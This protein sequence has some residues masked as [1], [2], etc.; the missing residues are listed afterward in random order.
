M[1]SWAFRRR[2]LYLSVIFLII[3]IPLGTYTYVK[4]QKP[5]SCMDN[6][7]NQNEHGVDCGGICQVACMYEVQAYPTI[8]WARAYYVS[9]G[10][11]NLVA[12]LQNPNTSYISKPVPYIFNVYDQNNALIQSKEGVVAF[13]TTKL[14]PIFTP[15]INLGER[16]PGRVSFEFLEPITWLEYYGEK[17]ELEVMERSLAHEDENPIIEA[18]IR[19]K[20]LHTYK[21]VE[22]VAIAYDTEGNGFAA[23]RTF[24][25]KIGDRQDVKVKFTW[26]EPFTSSSTKIEVIPKLELEAYTK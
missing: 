19:N 5:P 25:D 1:F 26:P 16:T 22:V 9:K 6:L 10:I 2:F 8:Q 17:P 23:S 7:K 12:Y 4:L 20:T 15:T 13:P 11:Y 14:F 3:V 21:N 18:K 24:V